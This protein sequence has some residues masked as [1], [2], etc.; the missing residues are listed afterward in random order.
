[1]KKKSTKE[2]ATLPPSVYRHADLTYRDAEGNRYTLVNGERNLTP[3]KNS[4]AVSPADL[5]AFIDAHG[6]THKKAADHIKK[7]QRQFRYY[8]AGSSKM[9]YEAWYT[10]HHKVTG[11]PPKE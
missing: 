4:V 1:M 7:S 11:Q 3:K 6:L 9:S 2:A 5:Q 8:I 10:L